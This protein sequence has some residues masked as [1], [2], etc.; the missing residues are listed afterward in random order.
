Q[1][2][3][4][5]QILRGGLPAGEPEEEAKEGSVPILV[6]FGHSSQ[7]SARDCGHP[8]VIGGLIQPGLFQDRGLAAVHPSFRRTGLRG[9]GYIKTLWREVSTGPDRARN[10]SNSAYEQNQH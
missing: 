5:H 3:F 4:M 9:K 8:F 10:Q 1:K 7:F 6:N 2:N